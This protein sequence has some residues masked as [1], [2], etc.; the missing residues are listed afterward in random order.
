[1]EDVLNNMAAE[2]KFSKW[3]VKEGNI[4]F[5]QDKWLHD[6]PLS[7][8]HEVRDLSNLSIAGCKLENGWN[9][10]LFDRLVGMEKIEQ[11]SEELGRVK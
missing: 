11:I 10:E 8:Q 9:V 7:E 2:Q 1:M 4:S 3:R 5:W 6:G